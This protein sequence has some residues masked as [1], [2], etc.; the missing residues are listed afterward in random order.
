MADEA[1]L[2]VEIKSLETDAQTQARLAAGQILYYEHIV[3]SGR[4]PGRTI[5]RAAVFEGPIPDY[6]CDFLEWLQIGAF[7]YSG[8]ALR[9][10]N[11]TARTI[12]TWM[13]DR[14]RRRGSGAGP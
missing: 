9:P 6:L 1:L 3:V 4:W 8:A 13:E 12:A 5:L 14:L 2:L 7:E 11:N 10:L